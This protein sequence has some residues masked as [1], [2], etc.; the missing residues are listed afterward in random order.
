VFETPAAPSPANTIV[1]ANLILKWL[2]SENVRL[3]AI[4]EPWKSP[5][6]SQQ[7]QHSILEDIYSGRAAAHEV[8][9]VRKPVAYNPPK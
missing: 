3:I 8:A 5:W 4:T 2:A 7:S 1:E 6:P 9:H